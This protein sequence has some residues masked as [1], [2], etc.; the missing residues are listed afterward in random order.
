MKNHDTGWVKFPCTLCTSRSDTK[1][2]WSI[3]HTEHDHALV[4]WRILRDTAE[5]RL[6]YVVAIQEWHLPVGFDPHL[7]C[8]CVCEREREG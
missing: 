7:C 3:G 5:V 2:Q 1:T 8:V 6:K 4:F